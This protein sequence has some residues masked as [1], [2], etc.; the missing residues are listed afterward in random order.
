MSLE[1]IPFRCGYEPCGYEDTLIFSSDN[2]LSA[3]EVKQCPKCKVRN[4]KRSDIHDLVKAALETLRSQNL[5][6]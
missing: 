2:L 3:Y 5:G 1:S 6:F 4:Y